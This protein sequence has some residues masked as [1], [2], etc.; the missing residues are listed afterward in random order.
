[1]TWPRISVVTPSYNQGQYLEATIRSVLLQG[2]PNLEY[3]IIDGGSIDNSI[4]V[5]RKYEPWLAY[6][7]SERDDG[8]ADA[9]NKGFSR[10]TG[11]IYSWL[12]SDDIYEP[13]AL[14]RVA[15][16]LMNHPD[17]ELVYGNGWQID[18]DGLRT[19]RCHWVGPLDP[20]T[21]LNWNQILQPAAF[22]RSDIWK[23]AGP[24][25]LAYY[26]G[27][28]WEWFIRATAVGRSCFIPHDLAAWRITPE[29][30]SVSADPARRAELASISRKHGGVLQ[31][32]YYMYELDRLSQ[33]MVDHLG[34]GFVARMPRIPLTA[35]RLI[36]RKRLA[37]RRVWWSA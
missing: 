29:I 17:V 3:I 31:P 12:N 13:G 33:W 27:L 19:S 2:Y 11:E 15:L 26:W 20:A 30:K 36:L 35:L 32:T 16:T 23:R 9:I 1:M 4:E 6:W 24:L 18:A 34:D 25:D 28:D 7:C 21:Q 8:Q 37:T 10:A 22:W 5:I 14:R